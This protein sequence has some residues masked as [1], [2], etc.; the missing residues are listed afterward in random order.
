MKIIIDRIEQIGIELNNKFGSE[1]YA[2]RCELYDLK[3]EL[4]AI[5]YTR[6]CE[7]L[8]SKKIIELEEWNIAKGYYCSNE[9]WFNKKGLRLNYKNDIWD[10]YQNYI[11]QTI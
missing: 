3:K 2:V 5:N 9:Q 4:E 10:K 8:N 11:K 1:G 6:C 7:L